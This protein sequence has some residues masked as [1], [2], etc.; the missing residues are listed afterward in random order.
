MCD[1]CRKFVLQVELSLEGRGGSANTP[2]TF[3]DDGLRVSFISSLINQA[4]GDSQVVSQKK[5]E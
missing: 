2:F 1:I 5:W 3:M 4:A